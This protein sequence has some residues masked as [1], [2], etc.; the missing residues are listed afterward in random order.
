[1]AIVLGLLAGLSL[2]ILG[3]E[4]LVRGAARAAAALGVSPLLIGLTV[5]AYGTSAPELAVSVSAGLT[6]RPALALANVVGSNVF[7]VLAIV[8]LA[9]LLSP[10]AADAR[11]VRREVPIMLAATVGTMLLAAD[12]ALTRGDGAVL[13]AGLVAVTLSQF[14]GARSPRPAAARAGP[15]ARGLAGDAGL[16]LAGLAALVAGSRWLVDAA[17]AGAAAMG[18]SELVVGLTIVAAGTSVPELA[19]SLVAAVRGER[20]LAIGNVVGSNVF[21]LLG[22]LGASA[23]AAPDGLTIADQVRSLDAWVALGAAAVLL[24]MAWSGAA[25]VRW[26][27][28]VLFAGYVAYLAAVVAIAVGAMGLP[29]PVTG[30]AVATLPLAVVLLA[31]GG[32]HRRPRPPAGRGAP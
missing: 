6:G 3:A 19:T 8:G 29:S 30:A 12:G 21:N 23:L 24:P 15:T 17:A 25:I 5:V 9:A 16:V 31:A 1:M 4:L 14:R 27:G 7:N 11:V 32:G 20:D 22:V 28:A 10:I 13:L 2:V 26:E 18:V